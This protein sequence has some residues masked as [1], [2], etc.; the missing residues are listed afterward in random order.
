MDSE[1]VERVLSSWVLKLS[2]AVSFWVALPF[3]AA[4]SFGCASAGGDVACL[5]L[6][7]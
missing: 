4:L 5:I 1:S 3:G 2:S 6:L 7:L